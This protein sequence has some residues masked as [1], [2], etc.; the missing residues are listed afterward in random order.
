MDAA[1]WSRHDVVIVGARVAGSATALLLARLGYDV[2]VVDQETF[3]SDTLSTH[4]IARSGVV[5]LQ[6]WGLLDEILDSGTP[7]IRQIT[8]HASGESVTRPIKDKAGVDFLIAPRRYVL[9][10]ILAAAAER[11]GATLR[12]GVTVTGVRR[13]GRGGAVGVY[14]RDHAGHAI[15]I[16]ARYVIGADGLRSLVARSV[17]ATV[18]E[19]RG[20]SGAT[21]YAYYSG[22]PWTGI[23]F[24]LA[25][26]SLAGVFP[27]HDGQACI[28]LCNPSADAKQT[29]RRTG[30]R[31]EAFAQL[32][33]HSA[34]QLADRLRHARRVSPVRGMLRQPNQLRQA[35][36]PGWALVGD[37][38]Y[39]RDAVTGHGIS[40][41]FRDAE[42]L[43]TALD[44]AISGGAGSRPLALYQQ[45]RDQALREVFEITCRLATFPEIPT[46]ID[47]QKRLSAAIDKEATA[48]AARPIP[49]ER[50]LATA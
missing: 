14:G 23:E 35:F 34:P 31:T 36:G 11:A 9:D 7:A 16:G 17:D 25:E 22:I 32:L 26:R 42:L 49:G 28:W 43:A 38:G 19:F 44:Q 13:D 4:S 24:F 50:L 46:F 29:R 5:Q 10:T 45:Q 41:A 8:F 3:P 27:T 1:N 2:A 40:D 33:A 30:S 47:L 39:H 12:L 18:T 21:Q 15:E 37:S 6:R 20:A 48:L